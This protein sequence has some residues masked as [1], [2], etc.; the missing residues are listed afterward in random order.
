M[1]GNDNKSSHIRFA[2]A[3]GEVQTAS[4]STRA[5]E[6]QTA[7]ESTRTRK[8]VPRSTALGLRSWSCQRSALPGVDQFKPGKRSASAPLY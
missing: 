7:H 3:T 8:V 5:E 4:V 2:A 1:A 6:E